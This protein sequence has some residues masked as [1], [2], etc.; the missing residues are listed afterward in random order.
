MNAKPKRT[1]AAVPVF[2]AC[3]VGAQVVAGAS[4]GITAWQLGWMLVAMITF[5][6]AA[7]TTESLQKKA[8][9]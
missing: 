6:G 8:I 7:I 1:W 2:G 9:T 5:A 3:S 4:S